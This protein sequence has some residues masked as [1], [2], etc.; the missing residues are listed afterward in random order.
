MLFHYSKLYRIASFTAVV[1]FSTYV[2]DM[3]FEGI[4]LTSPLE[5]ILLIINDFV[6]VNNAL[7]FLVCQEGH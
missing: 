5:I 1:G 6:I 7:M 4:S 3:V 2:I